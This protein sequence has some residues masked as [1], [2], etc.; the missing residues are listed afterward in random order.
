MC[1]RILSRR[2]LA[3]RVPGSTVSWNGFHGA[4]LGGRQGP[5]MDSFV[6]TTLPFLQHATVDRLADRG[7]CRRGGLIRIL[8]MASIDDIQERRKQAVKT[9]WLLA[10]VA[11]VIFVAF[12]LSGVLGS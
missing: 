3:L 10:F 4:R 9:A 12:I 8:E 2:Y 1:I 5:G 7:A 6:S 11:A